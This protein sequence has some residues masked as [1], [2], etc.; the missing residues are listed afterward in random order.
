ML[1][2]CTR[3]LLEERDVEHFVLASTVDPREI[4]VFLRQKR[5]KSLT[6]IRS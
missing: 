1:A 3:C 5:W 4:L 2:C 6:A